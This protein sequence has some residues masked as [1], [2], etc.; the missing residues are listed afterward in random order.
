[1]III[2]QYENNVKIE[3]RLI[4]FDL[5]RLQNYTEDDASRNISIDKASPIASFNK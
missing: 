3:L 2:Y 5:R 1:M 4:Y